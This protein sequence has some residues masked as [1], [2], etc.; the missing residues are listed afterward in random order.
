MMSSLGG[1][2]TALSLFGSPLSD[3]VFM[4]PRCRIKAELNRPAMTVRRA[5]LYV[6]GDRVLADVLAVLA[7]P[8]RLVLN[9][10]ET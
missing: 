5:A 6:L 9:D 10:E 4:H 7:A 8:V 2:T 1:S 3:Q